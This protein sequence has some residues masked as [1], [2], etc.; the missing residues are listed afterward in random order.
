[1]SALVTLQR[2]KKHNDIQAEQLTANLMRNKQQFI[3]MPARLLAKDRP[4]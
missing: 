2:D 3:T 1:M 4:I